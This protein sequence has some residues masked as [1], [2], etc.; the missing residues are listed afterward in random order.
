MQVCRRTPNEQA[1]VDA[2]TNRF[3][4]V[5]FFFLTE[6]QRHTSDDGVKVFAYIDRDYFDSQMEGIEAPIPNEKETSSR[7]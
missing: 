7:Q 5:S 1:S 6:S 3:K 4:S 2:C